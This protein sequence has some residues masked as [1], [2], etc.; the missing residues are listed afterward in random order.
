[1][2]VRR[3][4]LLL[5]YDGAPF[6][7][8]QRQPHAPTIQ[9]A[10]ES[11]IASLTGEEA[12]ASFAGRT[13]AGVHADGQVASFLTASSL[14]PRR[15]VRGLNHFLPASI[16]V[17]AAREVDPSFDPRRCARSREY[18]YALRIAPQ[19]Q[20]LRE[21]RAWVLS[22]PFDAGS[23]RRAAALFIGRRDFAAF[24]KAGIEG[25]A[26]RRVSASEL[27][28][29]PPDLVYR[30]EADAFLQHQVRRMAGA[31]VEVARGRRSLADLQRQLE[32][33]VPGS[34]GPVAPAKGLTLANVRYDGE[35]L[36][37]WMDSG[38]PR[39]Y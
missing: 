19:R 14:E 2:T 39:P 30:C 1:M 20:P 9:S 15:F 6:A 13:D 16:A 38:C 35:T 31:I 28:G 34:A 10:L 37:D 26:V 25:S 5:Q 36:P 33:A 27:L 11:A 24:A 3:L 22:P 23:A 18:R 8:S 21:D 12:R 29:E 17:Q 32:E 7:G 4:A